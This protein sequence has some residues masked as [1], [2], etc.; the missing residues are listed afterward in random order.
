MCKEFF[1]HVERKRLWVVPRALIY[2]VVSFSLCSVSLPNTQWL[3]IGFVPAS[4]MYLSG[5]SETIYRKID[6][7]L[8][9]VLYEKILYQMFVPC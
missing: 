2:Y 1:N 7:L 4:E 5:L 3:D 9:V 6:L 8:A